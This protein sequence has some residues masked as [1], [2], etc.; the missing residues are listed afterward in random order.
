MLRHFLA[1]CGTEAGIHRHQPAARIV[2]PSRRSRP[3]WG[4]AT[5]T[6]TVV[7][8]HSVTPCYQKLA[9]RAP[10]GVKDAT[11]T[12]I[13]LDIVRASGKEPVTYERKQHDYDYRD[14][15]SGI[16]APG[17]GHV[18]QLAERL[19]SQR[20][21]VHSRWTLINQWAAP[22][23]PRDGLQNWGPFLF[24]TTACN[25]LAMRGTPA[26]PGTIAH[27]ADGRQIGDNAAMKNKT[28]SQAATPMRSFRAGNEPSRLRAGKAR[29]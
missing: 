15:G 18:L 3:A 8:L 4:L 23:S 25:A 29:H 27:V 13:F 26:T 2:P 16:P 6:P 17:S 28:G 19:R 20:R 7:F 11:G 9:K 22:A 10:K 5:D 1:P 24:G 12:T 14:S 21:R